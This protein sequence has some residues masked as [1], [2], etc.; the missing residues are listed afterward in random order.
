MKVNNIKELEI[1]ILRNFITNGSHEYHT[2]HKKVCFFIIRRIYRRVLA[3]YRF[4]GVKI[5]NSNL[6]IDGHHR[7]IAYKLANI[8]FEEIKGTRCHTDEAKKF[9]DLEID[10]LQDWDDNH[11]STRKYCTDEFLEGLEK[12]N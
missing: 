3:G 1:T 8:E 4:G 7:Y 6:I 2:T 11:D 5:N 12:H 10:D 9:N